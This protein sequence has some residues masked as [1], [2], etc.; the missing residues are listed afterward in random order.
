MRQ[1]AIFLVLLISMLGIE[2]KAQVEDV[3]FTEEFETIGKSENILFTVKQYNEND[4][5]ELRFIDKFNGAL[6]KFLW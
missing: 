4:E 5:G 6:V 3:I 2:V 1:I